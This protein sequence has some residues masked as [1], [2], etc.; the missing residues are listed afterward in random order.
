MSCFCVCYIAS[1]SKKKKKKMYKIWLKILFMLGK[2]L[3]LL[4]L[5]LVF[6]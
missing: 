5:M 4:I 2:Q 1:D 3:I 6:I